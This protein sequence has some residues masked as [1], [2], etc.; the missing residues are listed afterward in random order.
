M[1]KKGKS[2]RNNRTNT[3]GFVAL[4]CPKN[5]VDAE[6]MLAAL[7]Q[8]GLTL[9]GDTDNADA[10]VVNTCGFIQPAVDEAL[11]TIQEIVDRK[12][13]NRKNQK[14]IVTG[15]LAQ[16]IGAE[17]FEKIPQIDAVVGLNDRG[18]IHEI[19]IELIEDAKQ[20]NPP[21]ILSLS[22]N[23][24]VPMDTGRLLITP[25]YSPYLRISEGCDRTCAFCTIPSI[26]GPFRSKPMEAV[27]EEA[28]ELADHGA[29][30]LNLIAQD[31]TRYGADLGLKDGLAE[32]LEQLE[33]VPNLRWV[34]VMYQNPSG[35][36]NRIIETF[37]NSKIV[38][39][40]IDMPIQHAATDILR[41]M[42][43]P[44]TAESLDRLI[45]T[46]REK[47]PGLTLRSTV[48]VGY[49]GETEDHFDTLIAAIEKYRF[50]ALGAF[51]YYAEQGT[52]AAELPDQV[53][54]DT[55]QQRLDRL[56]L[57]Q[58]QVAFELNEEKIGTT[59]EMIVDTAEKKRIF[60]RHP[61]QAP[62]IDSHCIL[63][64]AAKFR[65]NPGEIIPVRISGTQDYD[66]IVEKIN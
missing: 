2:K 57:A 15:C 56:M 3:I 65:P 59:T 47:I 34:R 55:K 64:K 46:L 42:R 6:S 31:T 50:E 9:T 32:L 11:D 14:I 27:L 52:P 62:E 4:G 49:P 7:T 8:A 48:I 12:K 29:V 25:H 54:E 16:R 36:T 35:I 41:A 18:K 21:R 44:D 39:P 63:K 61:G 13:Q 1:A 33:D 26:R 58:Q 17:L 51:S 30:E 53:D 60:G 23:V 5:L 28:H 19:A 10:V 37:A 40:Y 22:D 20:T 66:L 38:V 24:S 45:H 43:R